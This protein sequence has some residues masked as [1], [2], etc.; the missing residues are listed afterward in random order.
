MKAT[1]NLHIWHF[2]TELLKLLSRNLPRAWSILLHR[3]VVYFVYF[4]LTL[5]E[6]TTYLFFRSRIFR[7]FQIILSEIIISPY[8]VGKL[9]KQ[10]CWNLVILVFAFCMVHKFIFGKSSC[11]HRVFLFLQI[12]HK[13]IFWAAHWICTVRKAGKLTS[14]A[15]GFLSPASWAVVV[16]GASQTEVQW[17][18]FYQKV[19]LSTIAL[20]SRF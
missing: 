7:M 4:R 9:L 1:Y 16:F 20:D 12:G 3:A 17:I 11:E 5:I 15:N 13:I 10:K 18:K 2:L 6:W 8:F 19:S 14:I